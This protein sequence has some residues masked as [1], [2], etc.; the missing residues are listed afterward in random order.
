MGQIILDVKDL[1]VGFSSFGESISIVKDVNFSIEQGEIVGVVGESG[2]GK[3]MTAM[4]IMRLIGCPPG[5][6]TGEIRL[7]GK[8]LL[9]LSE[10]EMRQVR[11]NKVSMIFQEPMTSLNPVLTVGKQLMEVFMIHQKMGRKQAWDASV[12]ALR[13]VKIAMPEKRM[14]AYPHEMSG[15]MRQRVMIAMA[16]SCRPRLL[17]ADEPTTA[18]DVTIQAQ[19]LK[20]MQQLSQQIGASV[21]LITHDLGVVSEVCSR[22]IIL[23]C[24]QV[25]EEG[26]TEDLFSRPLH[27]YTE[28]LLRSLPVRGNKDRLYAIPGSV[29]SPGN[30]PQGCVFCPRCQYAAERCYVQKPEY[31]EVS[32]GH[33][34]RCLR[35][36]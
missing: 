11:G 15:G 5:I 23:Y 25:V 27:P 16:L 8:N 4:A 36:I 32:S 30:M 22:A 10:Q 13:M 31:K 24:G 3:S 29:P 1:N 34:V 20:L 35:Y 12:E 18:L 2:C 9:E 14:K 33:Y 6:I 7:D 26:Q 17:I 28:G 19:I 21:M